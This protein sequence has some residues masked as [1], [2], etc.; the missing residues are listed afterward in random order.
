MIRYMDVIKGDREFDIQMRYELDSP[1][2]CLDKK[3]INTPY[4]KLKIKV[5]GKEKRYVSSRKSKKHRFI[6]F[7]KKKGENNEV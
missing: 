4:I 1:V 3:P 2:W 7:G 5:V 6:F